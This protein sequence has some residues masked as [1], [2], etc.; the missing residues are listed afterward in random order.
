M[1]SEVGSVIPVMD[2]MP[3]SISSDPALLPEAK[4]RPGERADRPLIFISYCNSDSEQARKLLDDLTKLADGDIGSSQKLFWGL[5]YKISNS[6]ARTRWTVA[7]EFAHRV[8]Q[9]A[10]T[11]PIV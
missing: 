9:S 11:P 2:L 7:H 5:F 1:K 10:P 8:A 4:A 6:T 3:S